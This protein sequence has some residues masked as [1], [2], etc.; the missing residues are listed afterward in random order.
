MRAVLGHV[1]WTSI[2]RRE[3]LAVL[4]G[5]RSFVAAR[6]DKQARVWSSVSRELVTVRDP[7]RILACDLASVWH[8]ALAV[9][10]ASPFGLG[11]GVVGRVPRW[12]AVLS[13]GAT[14]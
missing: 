1:T 6:G 10:D 9:S 11:L 13:A 3:V 4:P 2:L 8:D 14:R 5:S 7:L 12:V